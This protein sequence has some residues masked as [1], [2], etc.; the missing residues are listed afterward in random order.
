MVRSA[1]ALPDDLAGRSFTVAEGRAAGLSS[2]D[3]RDPALRRPARGLRATGPSP[4]DLLARCRELLPVLPP[5][6]VFSHATALDLLGVDR[7]RG[8]RRPDDVHVEVGSGARP[9]RRRGVVGHRRSGPRAP[10]VL[11]GGI[12]AVTAPRL[13]VQLAGELDVDELV[14]AGDALLRRRDARVGLPE[15]T[16][17]VEGLDAGARGLRRLRRALPLLR[18]G[19]DSCQ[20][21][22]LRL[23]LVRDGLPCPEVN[24]PVLDADGRFVALPDL[25]YPALRLAVEYDGDVHRTDART[26][27]RDVA[28][29]QALEHEGWRVITCTAD[30]VRAPARALAWIRAALGPRRAGDP[31]PPHAR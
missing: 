8:L 5:Q 24:R 10:V 25:S 4:A 26:W 16:R 9:P 1:P 14:V 23:T 6:A 15:L 7:P 22:R 11:V 20:E 12:P 21:T 27:R 2:R 17:A 30:D 29:R 13:W 19:T 18:A 28:R 31:W 3:L